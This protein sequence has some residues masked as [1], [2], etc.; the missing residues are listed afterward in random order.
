MTTDNNQDD[1]WN[2]GNVEENLFAT[3]DQASDIFGEVPSSEPLAVVDDSPETVKPASPAEM[4][5]IQNSPT[6]KAQIDGYVVLARKYRPQTFDD[7]VG[8]E[9]VQ[10]ALRGA[11]AT[12]QISHSYLFSGP[13]GTGKTSTARILAKAVNCQEGGPRPDPCGQ[14]SSCRSITLGSSLDVIEIDAASNTGV[15][16]IRELKSGVVLAPFSRYKV[17]I[18]DEVHMLSNQAFNALLKT[19]EEPPPQVIFI[20]ATTELH[21]VPE[22]ILSRCQTFMFRRFS[23][24]ELKNQLGN[25][26]DIE[27]A[28]RNINVA[29]EDREKI[30]ELIARGAEG[31][32]RDAQVTLDQV[33]VLSKDT[34]D[35]ESVR[36]FL[37]MADSAALDLF[38]Q[39]ISERKSRELL[40]LIDQLMVNGQDLE[41]FVKGVCEHM[42]DLLLIKCAGRDTTMVTVSEDRSR[43]LEK[44]AANLPTPFLVNAVDHLLKVVGD[45]KVSGQPRILLE[46][47]V[48]KLALAEPALDIQNILKR[49][50]ALENGQSHA[51][52][53]TVVSASVKPAANPAGNSRFQA[54]EIAV[55]PIQHTTDPLPET[56][57][58]SSYVSVPSSDPIVPGNVE[59][60]IETLL[61]KLEKES[62]MLYRSLQKALCRQEFDGRVLTLGINSAH[63]MQKEVLARPQNISSLTEVVTGL[64]GENVLVRLQVVDVSPSETM[65]S[66]AVSAPPASEPSHSTAVAVADLPSDRVAGI[67]L[68]EPVADGETVLKIYYP[69]EIRE[70]TMLEV[71]SSEF[72]QMLSAD[73]TM[74]DLVE[75]TKQIFGIEETAIKFHRSTLA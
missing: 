41:L 7:I 63:K 21:K 43:E 37:G 30:L 40:E 74:S 2:T 60:M 73:A 29:S 48:L 44:I 17:Y 50:D 39:L 61:L 71:K 64:F 67:E 51:V 19:L 11:I 42:R 45:M 69:E 22:T 34:M 35:F 18:V 4:S 15:D 59:S 49:L 62:Q 24:D 27:A 52:P 12:G 38:V 54:E 16:N 32:M 31:G 3:A 8:Q 56:V 65:A 75:K 33:L 66:G 47:A 53:D 58:E 13:R 28:N 36:R 55:A 68:A 6:A 72:K 26:L 20:L 70:K 10:Q 57:S 23:L 14:C 5:K 46:L 9:G 1:L 25:I